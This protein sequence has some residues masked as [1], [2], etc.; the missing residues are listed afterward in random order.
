MLISHKKI[1]H[2]L[3]LEQILTPFITQ[4]KIKKNYSKIKDFMLITY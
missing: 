2:I 3:Q 1:S 4:Y